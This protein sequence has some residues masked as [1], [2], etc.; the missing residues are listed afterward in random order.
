MAVFP[1][2]AYV[3]ARIAVEICFELGVYLIVIYA[4]VLTLGLNIDYTCH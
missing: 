4:N 1:G 2:V 3:H